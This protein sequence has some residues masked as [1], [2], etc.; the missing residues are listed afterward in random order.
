MASV[1]AVTLGS[2]AAALDHDRS[3]PIA[4]RP[5]RTETPYMRTP[6]SPAIVHAT[7]LLARSVRK[8]P[9]PVTETGVSG[10]PAVLVVGC[11]HGDEPAGIA[12]ARDLITDALSPRRILLWVIP[13]LNPTAWRPVCGRMPMGWT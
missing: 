13:D 8:R 11:I 2:I 9:I 1:A 7:H 5:F 12:V 3:P 6:R 10:G 4:R